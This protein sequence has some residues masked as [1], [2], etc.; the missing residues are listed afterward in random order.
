MFTISFFLQNVLVHVSHFWRKKFKHSSLFSKMYHCNFLFRNEPCKSV[1]THF[2]FSKMHEHKHHI[3]FQNEFISQKCITVIFFLKMNTTDLFTHTFISPKCMNTNITF[4][5]KM[6][7]S[8]MH[9][10]N[11][12]SFL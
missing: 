6:N 10:H 7:S 3:Y 12:S 8:N 9:I 4:I 1:H 11:I 5:F 2:H